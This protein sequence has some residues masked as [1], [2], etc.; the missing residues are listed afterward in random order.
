MEEKTDLTQQKYNQKVGCEVA[1]HF[2]KSTII[3]VE[4]SKCHFF[5][6][7]RVHRIEALQRWCER[8][9]V[10][11][12]GPSKFNH[13]LHLQSQGS[14]VWSWQLLTLQGFWMNLEKS[15]GATEFTHGKV[16]GCF[17]FW[18]IRMCNSTAKSAYN[19]RGLDQ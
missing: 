9:P 4:E 1:Q 16:V 15:A 18:L 2:D 13:F 6:C 17:F 19:T 5:L 10:G 12:P 8:Y 11:P 7:L 3:M 14:Q